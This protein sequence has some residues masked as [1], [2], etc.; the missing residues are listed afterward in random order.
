MPERQA[1]RYLEAARGA[2]EEAEF[3]LLDELHRFTLARL[4]AAASQLT[5]VSQILDSGAPLE[6]LEA[7]VHAFLRETWEALDGLA[8]EINLCMGRAFPQAALYDPFSMTRQCRFYTVRKILHEDPEAARHP[9]S[10]LLWDRTRAKPAEAY[11][12]F[13][14]LCNLSVFATV[15][16]VGEDARLPGSGDLPRWLRGLA[17]DRDMAGCP[18]VGGLQD[19]YSWAEDL[20]GECYALLAQCLRQ[21]L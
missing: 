21:R 10:Q 8:R 6:V 7:P 18:L 15:P 19:I 5:C 12:R 13:S 2:L 1:G 11:R 9:L 17:R 4:G 16:L 3:A 14:F 20:V